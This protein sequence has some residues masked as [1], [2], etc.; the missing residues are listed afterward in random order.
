MQPD[1]W[2]SAG[3][4]LRSEAGL[5]ATRA[6]PGRSDGLSDRDVGAGG[7]RDRLEPGVETEDPLA[8]IDDHEVAVLGQPLRVNRAA[9]VD[10]TDRSARRKR[11]GDSV[12]DGPRVEARMAMA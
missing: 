4:V 2:L 3:R 1:R 6:G 9:A 5:V 11:D 8:V 7:H 10:R 12:G